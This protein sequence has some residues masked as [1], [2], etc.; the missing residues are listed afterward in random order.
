MMCEPGCQE[1]YGC[2][3]RG[4]QISPRVLETRTQNWRPTITPPKRQNRAVVCTVQA[5]GS[6]Q[7]ILKPDGVVLRHKEYH[8]K[9]AHYDD[10]IK[11]NN[12]GLR[13]VIKEV[14]NDG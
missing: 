2:R 12:G 4:V 9:R 1:H 5:D 3:L 8:E 13:P 7:P 11:R 6:T 10:L 14:V